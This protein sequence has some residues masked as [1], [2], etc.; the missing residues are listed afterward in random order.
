MK[1]KLRDEIFNETYLSIVQILFKLADPT[2]MYGE[3][4]RG[5]GKTTHIMA[6]RLDRVQ[7]SMP[8]SCLVLG[9]ATYKAIFDNIL[10][11]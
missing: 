6:P 11:G 8:G 9:A 5:S 3:V 10:P 4:G 2:F 1:S 7:N